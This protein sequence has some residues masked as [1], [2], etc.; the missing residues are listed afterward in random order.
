MP[1]NLYNPITVVLMASAFGLVLAL[2]LIGVLLWHGRRRSRTRQIESRLRR[3]TITTDISAEKSRVL[4]LW[5]D[6]TETTTIV[7]DLSRG[8]FS[9]IARLHR[10][11]RAAGVQMHVGPFV[12]ALLGVMLLLSAL[13]IS[14]THSALSGL[15]LSLII[16]VLVWSQ[17]GKRADRH[18]ALFETQLADALDL[19]TRSLRAGHPLIGSFRIVSE[20][21]PAPVSILFG[22]ICQLQGLGLSMESAIT[23][24]AL[25][26]ES[27]DMKLFTMSVVIQLKSGGNLADMMGRLA[28]VIRDRIRLK[29]R[30]RV[31]TAQVQLSRQVLSALPFVLLGFLTATKPGYMAPL[32]YTTQGRIAMAL[33]AS[34]LVLG[35]WAMKRIAVIRY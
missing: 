26:S 3:S 7:P 1:I 8:R 2:W 34:S 31:L 23:E 29:K 16:L 4:R 11:L 33:A 32:F 12:F 27:A 28:A 22:N 15:A 35:M 20:E 10:L 9:P 13:A 14:L 17:L 30:V 5:K 25:E 19:C 24:V 21:M 18:L 6:G